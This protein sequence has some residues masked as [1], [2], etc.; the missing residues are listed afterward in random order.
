MAL[1]SASV[2]NVV[3]PTVI[4]VVRSSSE[5]TGGGHASTRSS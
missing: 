3:P 5:R 2:D 1:E 4:A